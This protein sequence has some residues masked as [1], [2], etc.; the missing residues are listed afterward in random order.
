MRREL[1]ASIAIPASITLAV[2]MGVASKAFPL[3]VPG[4]WEWSRISSPTNWAMIGFGVFAVVCF[5]WFV[6]AL[7]AN[8]RK[9]GGLWREALYLGFVW[10]FG[11]GLHL[12]VIESAPYGYGLSRWPIALGSSGSS[13][14]YTLARRDQDEPRISGRLLE[15]DQGP[16]RA[17]HRHS[18]SRLADDQPLDPRTHDLEPR[19]GSHPGQLRP[20]VGDR[21]FPRPRRQV[22]LWDGRPRRLRLLGAGVLLACISTT[23][24]LYILARAYVEPSAALAASAFW[25]FAPAALLFQPTADAAYPLVSTSALAAA[26]WSL[27]TP[28]FGWVLAMVSG[29][30]LALGTFF[31]LAFLPIGLVAAILVSKNLRSRRCSSL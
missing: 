21:R 11:I 27:E 22:G 8:L 10:V 14:Y 18:S 24:P 19:S 3:G 30:F 31:T 1:I 6:G 12:V 17:S 23:I 7:Q 4:E 5:S 13:G 20:S 25:I 26:A 29:A 2:V 15:V 28:R 9:R 16:G